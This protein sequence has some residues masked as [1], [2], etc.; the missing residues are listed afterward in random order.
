MLDKVG[1]DLRME[2]DLIC[3]VGTTILDKIEAADFD[4]FTRRPSIRRRDR[5]MA[6]ARAAKNWAGR[7]GLGALANLWR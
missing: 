5:A 1:N 4:V 7:L 2:L 3:Q 6:A